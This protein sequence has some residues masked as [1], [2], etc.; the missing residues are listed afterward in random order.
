M[1]LNAQTILNI[2]I[3]RFHKYHQKLHLI[4]IGNFDKIVRFCS[5]V[6][7]IRVI[8]DWFPYFLPHNPRPRLKDSSLDGT[9]KLA[10]KADTG[11]RGMSS[12]VRQ[13]APNVGLD[14]NDLTSMQGVN[15]PIPSS[16]LFAKDNNEIDQ[17]YLDE[18]TRRAIDYSIAVWKIKYLVYLSN[19]YTICIGL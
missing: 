19:I 17:D 12:A 16:Y 6:L 15:Q 4:L 5:I 8:K 2:N 14:L 3:H 13:I 1:I 7:W 9:T 10:T 18:K 11:R